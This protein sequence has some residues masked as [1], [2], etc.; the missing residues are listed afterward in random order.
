MHIISPLRCFVPREPVYRYLNVCIYKYK[1]SLYNLSLSLS[2][3]T[4]PPSLPP[5]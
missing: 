1:V 3:P 4:L 5:Q 2:P